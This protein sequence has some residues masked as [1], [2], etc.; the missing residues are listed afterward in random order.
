[1][2]HLQ[3]AAVSSCRAAK[4]IDVIMRKFLLAIVM[5]GMSLPA[6]AAEIRAKYRGAWCEHGAYA[7]P[8]AKG[9]GECK[10]ERDGYVLVTATTYEYGFEGEPSFCRV[11]SVKAEPYRRVDGTPSA[12]HIITF[13]CKVEEESPFK[14]TFRFGTSPGR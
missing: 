10:R 7:I 11:V 6:A 9:Q 8:R 14:Q 4:R 2:A 13:A 5:L 1:M 3:A 12:D